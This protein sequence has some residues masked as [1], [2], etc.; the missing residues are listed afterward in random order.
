ME[1]STPFQWNSF[2]YNLLGM[3]TEERGRLLSSYI[4][5]EGNGS[6]NGQDLRT[7]LIA[8][9]V[10]GIQY[11]LSKTQMPEAIHMQPFSQISQEMVLSTL[12]E[13]KRH[14]QAI[15]VDET[16]GKLIQGKRTVEHKG[17]IR[18]D[19]TPSADRQGPQPLIATIRT[20]SPNVVGFGFNETTYASFL[21]NPTEEVMV[22]LFGSSYRW[23]VVKSKATPDF[24]AHNSPEGTIREM[25]NKVNSRNST[26]KLKAKLNAVHGQISAHFGLRLFESV[27]SATGTPS[28]QYVV[29]NTKQFIGHI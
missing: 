24:N 17:A 21:T 1:I 14:N 18:V 10:L 6:W 22:M 29:V 19:L 16:Q 20:F 4:D 23:A 7:A 25:I 26:E 8:I 28:D 15:L 2:C 3:N 9:G 13:L 12:L 5:L 11:R 27:Q